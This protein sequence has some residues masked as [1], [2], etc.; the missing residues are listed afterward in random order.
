MLNIQVCLEAK[1]RV[2]H[3]V[4]TSFKKGTNEHIQSESHADCFLRLQEVDILSPEFVPEE[5]AVNDAFS[6]KMLKTLKRRV[7]SVRPAITRNWIRAMS[8]PYLFQDSRQSDEKQHCGKSLTP[9][10]SQH[11]INYFIFSKV[12]HHGTRTLS[13][14]KEACICTINKLPES[15]CSG[16]FVSWNNHWRKFVDSPG[17]YFKEFWR[18][19]KIF[20]I[21]LFFMKLFL[22][23]CIHFLI[24]S[25]CARM[26]GRF[27]KGEYTHHAL[28]S[29]LPESWCQWGSP[30]GK[31][32]DHTCPRRWSV[33]DTSM[34]MIAD[35]S[36]ETFDLLI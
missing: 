32:G 5:S 31:T 11:G 19:V 7:E 24:M 13:A 21:N 2:A 16:V 33:L 15:T 6:L 17:I 35:T 30:S 27:G 36:Y 1:F 18:I 23:F 26:K 9:L 22:I 28:S 25:F 8:Q 29:L 4:F 20:Q 12:N 14:L 34:S 10:Q 3:C